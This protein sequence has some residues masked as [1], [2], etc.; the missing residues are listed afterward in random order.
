[1]KFKDHFSSHAADYAQF[2]PAYPSELFDYL[3]SIAPGRQCAWDCA[4][5]NGQAAV[6]LSSYFERVIAT[7]ASEQQIVNARQHERVDYRVALA[8]ASELND[9]SIDLITVA[10]ALHWFDLPRFFNEVRRV[11]KRD[12][13]IA[14]WAYTLL[15]IAPDIDVLV[16]RFYYETTGPF[17]AAE[18]SIVDAG[19][20]MVEFPF[21][22][23]SP[24]K[25]ELPTKWSLDQLLGY[26]R[27]WSAT[28]NFIAAKGFDPVD[29]LAGDIRSLWG[30]PETPR[31]MRWPLHLR[32]G[33]C[34]K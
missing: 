5:G 19:Y 30:E 23:L 6:G 17:W 34:R 10:Q 3:A 24:P 31:K 8:E 13:I 20:R 29:N 32:V 4:T 14:V 11:A 22:E 9:E 28:K 21:D 1:M 16:D 27:T 12:G 25:F 33:I 15:K 18:R 26:L 2:R 7:D